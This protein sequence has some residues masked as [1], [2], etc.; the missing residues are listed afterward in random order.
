MR[1]DGLTALTLTVAGLQLIWSS[2]GLPM[3]RIP[4]LLTAAPSLVS[5]GFRRNS[6]R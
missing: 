4:K 1:P 6:Q 5:A 3:G 2:L